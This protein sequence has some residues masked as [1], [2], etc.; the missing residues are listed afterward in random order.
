[1]RPLFNGPIVLRRLSTGRK[2]R[3]DVKNTR[4]HHRDCLALTSGVPH[5]CVWRIIIVVLMR[6]QDIWRLH[7]EVR[8]LVATTNQRCYNAEQPPIDWQRMEQMIMAQMVMA[9]TAVAPMARPLHTR[10]FLSALVFVVDDVVESEHLV[11]LACLVRQKARLAQRRALYSDD[12]MCARFVVD[13]NLRTVTRMIILICT[14]TQIEM[15]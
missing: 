8:A 1:M 9:H 10:G 13:A 11:P 5:C 15:G 12:Q 2:A 4:A 7:D 6:W 14:C 3:C